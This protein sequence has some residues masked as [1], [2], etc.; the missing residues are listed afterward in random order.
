MKTKKQFQ[1]D[2]KVEVRPAD[3]GHGYVVQVT[4]KQNMR[5]EYGSEFAE[6][7]KGVFKTKADAKKVGEQWVEWKYNLESR[8]QQLKQ[9]RSLE[10]PHRLKMSYDLEQE[11]KDKKT[12][13]TK[14][15]NEE[16][17]YRVK[18]TDEADNPR[19]EM[20]F[21]PSSMTF[22]I[23][24]MASVSDGTLSLEGDALEDPRQTT[25][26]GIDPKK[27]SDIERVEE[28]VSWCEKRLITLED[29]LGEPGLK[30]DEIKE[31][32]NEYEQVQAQLDKESAR[33]DKLLLSQEKAEA[34]AKK[35]A[36]KKK[37]AAKKP[38]KKKTS[39]KKPAKKK[40][41]GKKK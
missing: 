4:N 32:N 17:E 12:E 7:A 31:L 33:L 15:I 28:I 34:K 6:G 25:L 21:R 8:R 16:K 22:S 30:S 5:M 14:R 41:K 36:A 38:A 20:N 23:K 19:V 9:Q 39:K 37:T 27:R 10:L 13:A 2:W 18:I 40:G 3:D 11:W 35:K 29:K 26:P 24:D 1:A